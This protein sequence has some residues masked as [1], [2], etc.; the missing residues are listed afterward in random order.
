MQ[1]SCGPSFDKRLITIDLPPIPKKLGVMISGGL[2]SAIL[3]YL[4]LAQNE[5]LGNIHE[6]VPLTVLR[7]E[8]SKN[9]AKLVVAHV[10]DH[11]KREYLD[12]IIVGDPQLPEEQQVKSG[13]LAAWKLGINIVYTGLIEQLPQHMVGWQ[14]IPYSENVKFK[15]PLAHLNKSHIIDL[16]VQLEQTP[17]FYITHSCSAHEISRCRNCNG[18]DERQWG[19]EQ[20]GLMDPGTI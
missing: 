2:D 15:V 16:I 18:C 12:P 19:F 6:V 17:L 8:G 20:L 3:Y 5:Q 7:K 14:P 9:F 11:F 4:I 1:L 13:V 10:H